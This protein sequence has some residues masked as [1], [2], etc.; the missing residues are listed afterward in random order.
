MDY[1]EPCR[2]LEDYILFNGPISEAQA[3]L[4]MYQVLDA[5]KHCHKHGVYHGDIRSRNILVTLHSLEL[6]L[7]DFRCARLI[8]SEGFNSSEYQGSEA[9]TPPE[10]LMHSVFHAAEAERLGTGSSAL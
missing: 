1:P 7:I 9:Y 4:F 6:N 5:V 3:R 8:R 10:V 2:T